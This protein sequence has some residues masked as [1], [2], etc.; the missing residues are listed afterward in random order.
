M[1]I[2]RE[3]RLRYYVYL[4]ALLTGGMMLVAQVLDMVQER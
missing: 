2:E 1:M 3:R 4:Y